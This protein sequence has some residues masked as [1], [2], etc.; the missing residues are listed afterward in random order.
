MLDGVGIGRPMEC[1]RGTRFMTAPEVTRTA[2][3]IGFVVAMLVL[4]GLNPNGDLGH[5]SCGLVCD[6]GS[7]TK[8]S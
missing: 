2:L 7:E 3:A 1:L 6:T 8:P 4:G 5:G